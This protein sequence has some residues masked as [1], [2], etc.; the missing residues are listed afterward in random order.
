M[1][2]LNL[3]SA[4]DLFEQS[5]EKMAVVLGLKEPEQKVEEAQE[6]VEVKEVEEVPPQPKVEVKEEPKVEAKPEVKEEEKPLLTKFQMFDKEGELEVPRDVTFSFKANNK[7]YKD[8]PVDKVVQLAQMGF[9][10]QEREEQVTAAKHFVAESQKK[11]QG[12]TTIITELTENYKRLFEDPEFF[13][14]ARD[15]YL[16]QN[17]PEAQLQRTRAELDQTKQGQRQVA[18]QAAAVQFVTN[19]LHPSVERLLKEHPTVTEDE[20]MGRFY[21]LTSPLLERGQVPYQRLPEVKRLVETELTAYVKQLHLQRDVEKRAQA[22][23]VEAQKVKATQAKRVL[24]RAAAPGGAVATPEP[25]K[26]RKYESAE[27]WLESVGLSQN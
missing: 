13:E 25:Q 9:Y 5:D 3:E 4:S 11:E 2:D 16:K 12:Y 26:P 1:S 19:E 6:V 14:I 23:E 20:V 17:T 15:E 10:N 27:S 21:R 7:E 24:T 8:L 22:K 18:E